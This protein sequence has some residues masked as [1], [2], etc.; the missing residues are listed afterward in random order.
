MVKDSD[1]KIVFT[2]FVPFRTYQ[3]ISTAN[4]ALFEWNWAELAVLI[5]R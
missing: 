4:L 1:I 3:L 2:F 5:S